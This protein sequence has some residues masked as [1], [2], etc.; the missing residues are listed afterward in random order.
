LHAAQ[1]AWIAVQLVTAAG[2]VVAAVIALVPETIARGVLGDV[3]P[4]DIGAA[5]ALLPFAACFLVL[6]GV[7]SA[8]GGGLSG[9][10]DARG[11]LLIAI[12]GGWAVGLPLGFVLAWLAPVPAIGLWCGLL[13][14]A[15]LTAVLY[16]VRLRGKMRDHRN[17]GTGNS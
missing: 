14:G 15:G 8:A 11:P 12:V 17:G 6:E 4:A 13:A 9:L 3:G 7:Q 1:S 5:A 10:R 2:L 16:L